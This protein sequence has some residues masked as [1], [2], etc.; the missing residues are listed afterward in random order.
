VTLQYDTRIGNKIIS[1]EL[2]Q[3]FSDLANHVNSAFET[4][5]KVKVQARKEGFSDDEIYYLSRKA[6]GKVKSRGQLDYLFHGKRRYQEKRLSQKHEIM[7]N[8]SNNL[9]DLHLPDYKTVVLRQEQEKPQIIESYQQNHVAEDLRL[10]LNQAN[11]KIEEQNTQIK[12]LEEKYK[13]LA[14]EKGISPSNSIPFIQGNNLRT[15]VI[16]S[17]VFREILNLKGSKMIYA[18]ILIDVSQNKYIR[19]EPVDDCKFKT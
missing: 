5:E 7:Q 17:Q 6:L 16:V 1:P 15:K 11:N 12:T 13:Q 4:L 18:N 3:L 14:S 10:Q 19:L 2:Q 9:P 8:N